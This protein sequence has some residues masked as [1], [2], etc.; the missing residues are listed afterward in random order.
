[1]SDKIQ[2]FVLEQNRQALYTVLSALEN[3]KEVAT[4]NNQQFFE[5]KR[6]T[7]IKLIINSMVSNVTLW[8]DKC[9]LNIP[10]IGEKFI[11]TVRSI[12]PSSGK[13]ALDNLYTFC[14]RF[15]YELY[16]T[17]QD[18]FVSPPLTEIFMFTAN[19]IEEFD[20]SA[21]NQIKFT[22]Q[23]MPIFILKH[24]LN[25]DGISKIIDFNRT[26]KH[27]EELKTNWDKELEEKSSRTGQLKES[28]DRYTTAFNFVGLYDG[29]NTLS[30]D[31]K[32]EKNILLACLIVFG[33]LAISPVICELTFI[34]LNYE[35]IS[36]YQTT[37]IYSAFPAISII[38]L[39]TYY[40]RIFLMNYKSVKSQLLQIELRKTLCRFIQDYADYSNK[41]KKEDKEA[42]TKFESVIFSGI[43]SNDEKLPSTFDGIDQ[44][45]KFISSVKKA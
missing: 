32:K 42:L 19:A 23:G 34:I 3:I 10:A 35:N 33:A 4:T 22:S 6:N 44:L 29:F 8:D 38:V 36:K 31:K 12:T 13:P 28:L 43:V 18:D 17:A 16:I 7:Y 45:T 11:E 2:F 39:L 14:Y 15:F 5:S 26:V 41:I 30:S 24:L 37:L 1:M 20:D 40:F 27:A 25:S 21:K 9:S